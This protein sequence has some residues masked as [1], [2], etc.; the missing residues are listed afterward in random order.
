MKKDEVETIIRNAV[1]RMTDNIIPNKGESLFETSTNLP[2]EY[3]EEKRN[4]K[5]QE[6]QALKQINEF[7]LDNKKDYV[8]IEE[9][10]TEQPI[11]EDLFRKNIANKYQGL[12][13]KIRKEEHIN[14]KNKKYSKFRDDLQTMQLTRDM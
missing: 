4:E 9:R 14:R 8:F 11:K 10:V 5:L 12:L 13:D 1:G 3:D 2:Y 7:I 6:A